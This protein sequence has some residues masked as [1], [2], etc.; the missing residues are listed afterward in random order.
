MSGQLACAEPEAKLGSCQLLVVESG[1]AAFRNYMFVVFDPQSRDAVV[2]DPGWDAV[3]LS[4]LLQEH[5]LDC[6]GLLVTHSHADHIAAAS[7]L[8]QLQGCPIYLSHIE[9]QVSGFR[10]PALRLTHGR[11]WVYCGTLACQILP[12]PGH[13]SGS[14]CFL[15]GDCLFTGDTLFM[16]G[17]GLCSG[18]TGS[19]QD[20]FESLQ[21]LKDCVPQDTRVYPGHQY[22]EPIGQC[23]GALKDKNVYLKIGNLKTFAMFC[24]RSGRNAYRPPPP[25]SARELGTCV[26][27]L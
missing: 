3:F 4:N 27:Q 24:G 10:D 9:A 21:R 5:G 17:V 2:I 12:T 19:V 26:V 15:V 6:R 16:E 13:T 1:R 8:A 14:C 25:S 11:E 18:P 23:F 22:L 7:E 20:M